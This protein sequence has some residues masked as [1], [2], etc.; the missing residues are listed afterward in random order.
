MFLRNVRKTALPALCAATLF[1]GGTAM[2]GSATV[3]ESLEPEPSIE[4]TVTPNPLSS[5]DETSTPSPTT[6]PEPGSDG[7]H[8]IWGSPTPPTYR[9]QYDFSGGSGSGQ[10]FF[11]SVNTQRE[12]VGFVAYHHSPTETNTAAGVRLF[13]WGDPAEIKFAGQ[14][15]HPDQG[16]DTQRGLAE[17]TF[18][19]FLKPHHGGYL[20]VRGGL[21]FEQ[22]GDD[23]TTEGY[24]YSR[25]GLTRNVS[26]LGTTALVSTQPNDGA[27]TTDINWNGAGIL[28]LPHNQYA[29]GGLAHE[30]GHP[31]TAIFGVSK[32]VK[33]ETHKSANDETPKAF[34]HLAYLADF[35]I[36]TE[37]QFALFGLTY[38][39]HNQ[40]IRE[41][42]IGIIE[43]LNSRKIL[44]QNLS[45][46]GRFDAVENGTTLDD[47]ARFAVFGVGLRDNLGGG[48]TL[49]TIDVAMTYN[50]VE[51][52]KRNSGVFLGYEIGA[53]TITG[54]PHVGTV[55]ENIHSPSF[56]VR[57]PIGGAHLRVAGTAHMQAD[58]KPSYDV[59]TWVEWRG[60]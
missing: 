58:E 22:D 55:K 5:H 14:F 34:D 43:G 48:M 2:A 29:F 8:S 4:Q 47:I 25:Y 56:G 9:I 52:W 19:E 12:R 42:I 53:T 37:T 6:R 49:E 38:G 15:I 40:F 59:T 17:I 24:L 45:D 7:K 30:S 46:L 57:W 41:P 60:H 51:D 26:V 16:H 21:E 32:A 50:L 3:N 27:A 1:L 18:R 28:N 13:P 23:T 44:N 31:L 11:G 54:I 10:G 36:S 39:P 35:R 20:K 33:S